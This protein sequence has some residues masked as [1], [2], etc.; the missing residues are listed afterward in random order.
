MS[1]I[2]IRCAAPGHIKP[3]LRREKN[4]GRRKM[5]SD[6][7]KSDFIIRE[8]MSGGGSRGLAS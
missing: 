5:L 3:N 4:A 7:H 1:G 2:G 8:R 6:R